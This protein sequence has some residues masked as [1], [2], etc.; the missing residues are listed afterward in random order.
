MKSKITLTKAF[1]LA[2]RIINAIESTQTSKKDKNKLVD[3]LIGLRFKVALASVPIQSD[4][5]ELEKVVKDL[6]HLNRM[7]L[8]KEEAIKKRDAKA[9]VLSSKMKELKSSIDQFNESNFIK[10]SK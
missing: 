7:E 5:C 2:K 10:V 9:E 4:Y 1:A 6:H 8:K 3:R